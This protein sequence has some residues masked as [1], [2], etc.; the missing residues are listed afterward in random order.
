PL[1]YCG[2]ANGAQARALAPWVVRRAGEARGLVARHGRTLLAVGVLSPLG[3]M[4][5]LQ[6]MKLAPVS[7][8]APARELSMLIAAFL[9]ARLL[10]EGELWRRVAGAALIASGVACLALAG[11]SG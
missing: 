5:A 6:A 2:R 7:H 1:V 11:S 9:G 4:L 3:Y 8:V 10:N